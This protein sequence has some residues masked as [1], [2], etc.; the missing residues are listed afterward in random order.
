MVHCAHLD[1]LSGGGSL[2]LE[3]GRIGELVDGPGSRGVEF[4]LIHE[5]CVAEEADAPTRRTRAKAAG[6]PSHWNGREL[7]PFSFG[8]REEGPA[9][10]S[11]VQNAIA[12]WDLAPSTRVANDTDRRRQVQTRT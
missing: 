1:H 4:A 6:D 9:R 7:L 11:V 5:H 3:Q 10:V 8:D 12:F 2:A